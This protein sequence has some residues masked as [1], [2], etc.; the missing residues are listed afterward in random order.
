MQI[1]VWWDN[2]K[3]VDIE[4]FQNT[5]VN[6]WFTYYQKLSLKNFYD[7]D[8]VYYDICYSPMPQDSTKEHWKTILDALE[9]LRNFGYKLPWKM[10]Q[11][12]DNKQSTL[13][14]LHRFFTYNAMW[15]WE[16]RNLPN[17]LDSNKIPNPFDPNFDLPKNINSAFWLELIDPINRSVHAL[18]KGTD[19]TENKRFICEQLP[20]PVIH[21]RPAY[22]LCNEEQSWLNFTEE[23]QRIN[24]SYF[25]SDLPLVILDQSILGKS[26]MQSFAED[27][28]FTAIDCTGRLGSYGGFCIDLTDHRKQIY[29]SEPFKKWLAKDFFVCDVPLEFPIGYVNNYQDVLQWINKDLKFKK[30]EF[31]N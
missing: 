17:P 21:V 26:V 30:I 12:F 3:Y 16:V 4:L 27:D 10:P 5:A 11:D 9:R 29:Q 31:V 22:A 25:D 20:L 14:V 13:N 24:Y 1:K 6:K 28:D 8:P 19:L 15:F 7:A 23:E 18:E 2:D